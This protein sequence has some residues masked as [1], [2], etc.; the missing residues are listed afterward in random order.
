PSHE[1]F[2]FRITVGTN[3]RVQPHLAFWTMVY[4]WTGGLA[5]KVPIDSDIIHILIG[6]YLYI[7][8]YTNN[9]DIY[10]V[11]NETLRVIDGIE[12]AKIS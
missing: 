5:R 4:G 6:L 2:A 8:R 10:N 11:L 9:I 12:G 3:N 7:T 1:H